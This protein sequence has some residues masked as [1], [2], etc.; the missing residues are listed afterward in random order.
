ML[1]AL[2]AKLKAAKAA[3]KQQDGA[4]A[5]AGTDLL[6]AAG[7][8]ADST[9]QDLEDKIR[10]LKQNQKDMTEYVPSQYAAAAAKEDGKGKLAALEAK[11]KAAK[12]A[13]KQQDG[14]AATVGT[15]LL[16]AAGSTA[17]STVQDLEDKIRVLKQSEAAMNKYVPQQFQAAASQDPQRNK[18]M[19]AALE[20]KLKA[21]KQQEKDGAAATA[22][23]D[24]LAGT[25][26]LASPAK[27]YDYSKESSSDSN[28]RAGKGPGGQDSQYMDKYAPAYVKYEKMSSH[29]SADTGSKS[30]DKN[31]GTADTAGTDLF[32][33]FSDSSSTP[34]SSKLDEKKEGTADTAATKTSTAKEPTVNDLEGEIRAA[35][36]EEAHIRNVQKHLAEDEQRLEERRRDDEKRREENQHREEER[37]RDEEKR[38]EEE[39]RD[40]EER[41]QEEEN[42]HREEERQLEERRK[43]QAAALNSTMTGLA[44]LEAKLEAAKA[45]AKAGTDLLAET[46]GADSKMISD[47]EAEIRAAKREAGRIRDAQTHR[48]E[49]EADLVERRREE[50][51]R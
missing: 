16:A 51:E 30:D 38:R 31:Q 48:A 23:T 5:T 36:R 3:A 14:A 24:R 18:A 33:I 17:D 41:R 27:D 21:A 22:G 7:S 42:Q 25:D 37:R 26:F 47:L 1:A 40:A 44:S 35:K 50:A 13:A 12:A 15:D 43:E 20:A 8:T 4:A 29:G 19:L 11:L 45:A 39:R 9:V 46:V 32:G 6:A 10:V 49:D 2:E 34:S 28:L